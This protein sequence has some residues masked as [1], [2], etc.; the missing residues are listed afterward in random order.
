MR[1]GRDRD[2]RE[3]ARTRAIATAKQDRD[4]DCADDGLQK[5]TERSRSDH[6]GSCD[7]VHE[8]RNDDGT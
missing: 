2:R 6:D 8:T 3:A 7:A 4:G 1:A 5:A